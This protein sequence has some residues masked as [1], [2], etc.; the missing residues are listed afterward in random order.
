MGGKS[1]ALNTQPSTEISKAL[2]TTR[3][4][5]LEESKSF[6]H[7]GLSM[8]N[9]PLS[10]KGS[11]LMWDKTRTLFLQSGLLGLPLS[12]GF[13]CSNHWIS[14]LIWVISF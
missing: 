7:G 3:L 1:P 12:L 10:K 13:L 6:V 4:T 14:A 11:C 5:L 8:E 9:V 2:V